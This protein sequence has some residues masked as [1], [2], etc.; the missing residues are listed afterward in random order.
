MTRL[1]PFAAGVALALAAGLSTASAASAGYYESAIAGPYFPPNLDLTHTS[2]G[3]VHDSFDAG[4]AFGGALGY[5]NGDGERIELDASYARSSLDR[6][7]GLTARGHLDVVSLMLNG[8]IDLMRNTSVVP[9]VGA[10]IGLDEVGAE[11]GPLRGQNWDP[12]YQI[13]A[14]LREHL[15][16][17]ISL[18][19]EYRFSQ[20]EATKLEGGGLSANQH[21]ASHAVLAGLTF[22]FE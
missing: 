19:G 22:K 5:D 18:F 8:E 15:M 12:G 9:Y 7:K 11:I 3:T 4:Y 6:V 17:N 20:S 21:F 13:E 10:G 14:G 2:T 16:R 1:L